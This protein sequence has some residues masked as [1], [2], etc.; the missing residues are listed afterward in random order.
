MF[1][2]PQRLALEPLDDL[3]AFSWRNAPTLCDPAMGCCSYHRVWSSIRLYEIDGAAP[4][5]RDFYRHGLTSLQG[6]TAPR[7]LIS[8]GADTGVLA[9]VIDIMHE[10]EITGTI[11]F[12][13]ICETPVAQNRRMAEHLGIAVE[14][15]RADILSLDIAP[16]DAVVAHSFIGFFPPHLR[17]PLIAKWASLLVPDGVLLF[18]NNTAPET[19]IE[20]RPDHQDELAARAVR[21]RPLAAAGGFPPAELDD[22]EREISGF[23]FKRERHV[24]PTEAMLRTAIVEAGLVLELVAFDA[25]KKTRGPATRGKLSDRYLRTAFMARKP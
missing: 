16:V 9:L 12:A 15:L 25:T 18:T 7:I 23:L 3:A 1:D 10:L 22:L 8:G 11:I 20:K 4:A 14:C 21:I 13:D 6:K 2:K 5:G 19:M 24:A 17:A